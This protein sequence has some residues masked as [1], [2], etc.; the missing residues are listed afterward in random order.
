[1]NIEPKNILPKA[2]TLPEV[3]FNNFLERIIST[4]QKIVAAKTS[5]APV[6]K[7]N[8]VIF[9]SKK[10]PANKIINPTISF[11]LIFSFKKINAS[12]PTHKIMV[13]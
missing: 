12:I 8:E 1:M 11:T 2:K 13:L 3:F 10:L 4:D 6:V 9:K 5:N 7:S